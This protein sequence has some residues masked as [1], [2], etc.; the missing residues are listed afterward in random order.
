LIETG[1][2]LGAGIAFGEGFTKVQLDL[3]DGGKKEVEL[4][5]M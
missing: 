4:G 1:E 2:V 3:L 5:E